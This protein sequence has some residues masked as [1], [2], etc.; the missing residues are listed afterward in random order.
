MFVFTTYLGS[1]LSGPNAPKAGTK[2]FLFKTTL[3]GLVNEAFTR[4]RILLTEDEITEMVTKANKAAGQDD[5]LVSLKM[6]YAR[7]ENWF[8]EVK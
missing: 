8:K 1:L 4:N 5:G 2:D 3:N 7:K 6:S